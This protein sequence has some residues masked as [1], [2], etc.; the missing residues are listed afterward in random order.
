MKV[1]TRN[2]FHISS[3]GIDVDQSEYSVE[4]R[5][6][7]IAAKHPGPSPKVQKILVSLEAACS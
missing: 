3:H 7:F 2:H 1:L 6:N 5:A 4:P